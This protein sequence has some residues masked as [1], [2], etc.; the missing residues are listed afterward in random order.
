LKPGGVMRGKLFIPASRPERYSKALASA[1]G[2]LKKAKISPGSSP[3]DTPQIQIKITTVA[4]T[5]SSVFNF[6]IRPEPPPQ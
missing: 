1:D 5:I 4:L 2:D 6:S 3:R